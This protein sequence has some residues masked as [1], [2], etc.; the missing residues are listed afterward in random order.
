MFDQ[1]SSLDAKAHNIG[2]LMIRMGVLGVLY[3][4]DDNEPP[5]TIF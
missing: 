2:A 4:S 3:Y 1:A 5:K